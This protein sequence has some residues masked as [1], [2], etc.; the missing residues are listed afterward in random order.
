MFF[1]S[2]MGFS[3]CLDSFIPCAHGVCFH[4]DLETAVV[5]KD[6]QESVSKGE[7]KSHFFSIHTRL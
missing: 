2:F 6:Y 1:Y 5:S 7:I 3:S 4:A